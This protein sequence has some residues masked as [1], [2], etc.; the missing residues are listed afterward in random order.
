MWVTSVVSAT[1]S[2][3]C[4]QVWVAVHGKDGDDSLVPPC[5]GVF[6]L[7]LEILCS[8]LHLLKQT[9][10]QVNKTMVRMIFYSR[11][12]IQ[13]NPCYRLDLP[14]LEPISSLSV[15][16]LL[17][18]CWAAASGTASLSHLPRLLL[19]LRTLSALPWTS[20]WWSGFEA[21][22]V[23]ALHTWCGPEHVSL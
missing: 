12:I 19:W 3:W 6:P 14:E 15:S 13:T 1:G 21:L 20:V 17:G 2:E 10:F 22:L 16:H 9:V 18:P 11:T 23:C 4:T 5:V 7:D 8:P